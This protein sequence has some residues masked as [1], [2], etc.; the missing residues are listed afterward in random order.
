MPVIEHE[1]EIRAP[2]QTV[3]SLMTRVEEFARYSEAIETITRVKDNRY[4]WKVRA[5]GIPLCFD[6]EVTESVP[7][8]RFSWRSVSGVPSRGTYRLTAVEDGTRIHLY[9]EYDLENALIEEAV[10][11]VAKPLMRRLSREIVG[12]VEARLQ[13]LSRAPNQA[14]ENG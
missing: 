9:L 7:P 12:N 6:V 5:A 13:S 11:K 14:D 10:R 1:V 8:E 2:R 3:F 4:R